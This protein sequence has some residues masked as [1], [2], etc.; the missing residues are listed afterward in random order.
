MDINELKDLFLKKLD[1]L[2]DADLVERY[3]NA[4]TNATESISDSYVK[5][6][7]QKKFVF[8]DVKKIAMRSRADHLNYSCSKSYNVAN[9]T[10][11]LSTDEISIDILQ[12][13]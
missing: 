1:N 11:L 12:A 2:T 9:A 5:S 3:N 7:M 4:S 13:A 8:L 10:L 6:V